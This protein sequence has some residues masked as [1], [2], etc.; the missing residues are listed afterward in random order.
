MTGLKIRL[1]VVVVVVV[2]DTFGFA[3]ESVG[4]GAKM[5]AQIASWKQNLPNFLTYLRI[6]L[7]PVI[8]WALSLPTNEGGY[9]AAVIFILASITDY[10]DGALA[11]K[12]QVE[13]VIGKFLDPVAD[14]LL[15]SSTLIMLIPLGRLDPI[16]VIILLSRD[17]LIS[18][19]RSIA[20]TQNKV[21]SAGTVGKW[22]TA[23]QMVAIPAVLIYVPLFGIPIYEIGYWILWIS[24]GL[25]VLSGIQYIWG[26]FRTR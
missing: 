7:V 14:K 12:F 19:L 16:M 20:A 4:V 26:Y 5:T 25:S 10:I 17:T 13:S 22:K 3:R 21:I 15:V 9:L 8:V 2:V 11:R 1:V 6:F 18:G 24:V 23:V